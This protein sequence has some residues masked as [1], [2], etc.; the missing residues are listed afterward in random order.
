M[1]N[2][3]LWITEKLAGSVFAMMDGMARIVEF[4]SRQIAMIIRTMI[5][6]NLS[7]QSI[8]RKSVCVLPPSGKG[9]VHRSESIN[10]NIP[11]LQM[12]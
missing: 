8:R 12:V 4:S 2:A 1:A 6:V 5:K 10:Q 11:Q 7:A 3:D 9:F